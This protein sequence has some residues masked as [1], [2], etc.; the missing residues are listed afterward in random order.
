M[1]R[2]RVEDDQ[3]D[4][5]H[6]EEADPV[7][8]LPVA[9]QATTAV[10]GE[11]ER[12]G[13]RGRAG[14]H[15][16]ELVAHQRRGEADEGG[17]GDRAEARRD[18]RAR[19]QVEAERRPEI[20][21]RLL[22][23]QLGV[24]ERRDHRGAGG[25]EDRPAPRDE[26][27]REEVRGEDDRRHRRD[28]D[29]LDDAVRARRVV[30]PPRGRDQVDVE[31]RERMRDAAPRLVSRHRDR[32]RELRALELVADEP[33]REVPPGLPAVEQ[34]EP[35][36]DRQQREERAQRDDVPPRRGE[37]VARQW[38][39]VLSDFHGSGSISRRTKRH[40][41]PLASQ[42][43]RTKSSRSLGACGIVTRTVSGRAARRRSGASRRRCRGRG[44]RASA[45]ATASGRRRRSRRPAPRVSRAARARG[46]GRCVRRRRR[47]RAVA[48]LIRAASSR[49]GTRR[50][51]RS[52][53]APT[54]SVQSSASIT[55][56]ARGKSPRGRVAEITP[57]ATNSEKSTAAAMRAASRAS[58]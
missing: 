54:S 35:D 42:A 9:A 5:D 36:E 48:V 13:R 49:R 47:A 32:A 50:A 27:P 46:C 55:R 53:D 24:H 43:S 40:S 45:D 57:Q 56:I 2:H 21:E 3:Q 26:H 19:E 51:P 4:D 22:E 8:G 34:A 10:A 17:A 30:D 6:D 23:Q 28:A 25:R 18:E 38:S 12:E 16:H 20:R 33:R 7:P 41:T 1:R 15:H 44:R 11:P 37:P 52:R 29:R 31:R 58:A 39:L 14:D